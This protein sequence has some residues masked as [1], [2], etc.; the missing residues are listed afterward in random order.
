[1]TV[2]IIC[3]VILGIACIGCWTKAVLFCDGGDE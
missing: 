2:P 1:M 3:I